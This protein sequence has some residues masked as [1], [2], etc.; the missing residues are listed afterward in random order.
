L[1]GRWP[2]ASNCDN[3]QWAC[4]GAIIPETAERPA[5]TGWFLVPMDELV[6]DQDSWFVSGMQGTG[7]KTIYA[8]S[9]L[10]VPTH[11]VIYFD[12]IADRKAPGC[13]IGNN[14]PALF[15]FSTFGGATLA[16]PVLGMAQGALNLF[17]GAMK[18]KLR[19]AM[20][21]GVKLTAGQNP[22]VQ[23]R[24]G[25]AQAM[26]NCAFVSLTS[27]LEQS[28]ER[29]FAGKAPGVDERIRVRM[30]LVQ[31]VRLSVDAVN[32]IMET[33][34][35]SAADSHLPLQRFWR[36]INAAVRHISFDTTT[37]FP[38]AGQHILGL[39]PKMGY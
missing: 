29:I 13:L 16:G 31:S 37:L 25:R 3:S 14:S 20:K 7:S 19:V 32:L 30:A 10:F 11:R 28:E 23:E 36:D 9:P 24:L 8:A 17:A 15:A 39:E 2:W 38:V 4:V 1:S 22:F 35:A 18:D 33:A 34:G 26:I 6:I 27:T 5:G 21:P 12:D